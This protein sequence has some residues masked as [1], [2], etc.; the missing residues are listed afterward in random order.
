[1]S[2]NP[3]SGEIVAKTTTRAT[4]LF[5]LAVLPALVICNPA[6]AQVTGMASPTPTIGATSPLGITTGSS[7]SP[8]GIPLGATE[9]ASP[10]VSPGPIVTGTTGTLSSGTTCSTVG[11]SP[12]GMFGSTATFDGGGV[13]SA[14]PATAAMSGSA[15]TSGMATSSGIAATSGMLETSGLSGMCG[16][17]STSIASSSTP[18]SPTTPGGNARTGI[19]LGST[20]IGNLGVSSAAAIPLSSV[21]PPLGTMGSVPTMPTMTSPTAGSLATS[22]TISGPTTGAGTPLPGG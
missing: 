6:L 19:P 12:S 3:R 22:G 7:V 15:A 8:T 21:S 4:V 10:G 16:A 17:G 18:T 20:E 9:I 14:S 1:M 5:V 11:S 2:D 13:G